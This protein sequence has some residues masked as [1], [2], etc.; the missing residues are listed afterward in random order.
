MIPV[1]PCRIGNQELW[2]PLRP[3]QVAF[4]L[5]EASATTANQR[6]GSR[7]DAQNWSCGS[8]AYYFATCCGNVAHLSQRNQLR[9][10]SDV[11]GS[12]CSLSPLVDCKRREGCPAVA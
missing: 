8:R 9:Q 7:A 10:W 6:S 2:S 11:C 4:R 12:L 3:P 1:L 5:A